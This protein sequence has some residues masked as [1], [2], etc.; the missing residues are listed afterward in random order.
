MS[1]SIFR[2]VDSPESYPHIFCY[3]FAV[4][5]R[6]AVAITSINFCVMSFHRI[7]ITC[8]KG[9]TYSRLLVYIV[10][11]YQFLAIFVVAT[12]RVLVYR[13]VNSP[14][15]HIRFLCYLFA[16]SFRHADAITLV[17]FC[18]RSLSSITITRSRRCTASRI[19]VYIFVK[20][21]FIPIFVVA[22]CR[23]MSISIF[24]N[25]D[26]PESYPHIFCYFFA[27]SYRHAVAITSINFCVMSFHRITITCSKGCTYS[28]LLVYIVVKYQFPAIFVVATCRVLFYRIVN[29]PEAHIRFLCNLFAFSFRH[30]D[31]ITI[32]NFCVKSCTYAF[33]DWAAGRCWALCIVEPDTL[34]TI[35]C[36]IK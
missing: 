32:V 8:S 10:V 33:S 16:S 23:V 35:I 17:N 19:L 5:Y 2:N 21:Q 27:V 13:I 36:C 12:C 15:A 4:S 18:V 11:K 20:Y 34:I 3:F 24:R 1:I 14:D 26:S 30:A 28:R 7:T 6:H 22:T 31:A 9:C 25:V 29:S